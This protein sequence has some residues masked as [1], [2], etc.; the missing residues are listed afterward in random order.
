MSLDKVNVLY[1]NCQGNDGDAY[2]QKAFFDILKENCVDIFCLDEASAD[3]IEFEKNIKAS[4]PS[5][6]FINQG[7]V[8]G[9]FGRLRVFSQLSRRSFKTKKK[10]SR[11]IDICFKKRTNL[12]F[13][14]FRSLYKTDVYEKLKKD[15][16]TILDIYD[17][18]L[19]KRFLIG[20]FNASPFSTTMLDSRFLNTI[21]CGE[22]HFNIKRNDLNT[23]KRINPSWSGFAENE[24]GI[25][26]TLPRNAT[27]L[28]NIGLQLFDQ[29]VF[30]DGLQD[31][32]V[33][34]SFKIISQIN[35]VNIFDDDFK[36]CL[37]DHLPIFFSFYNL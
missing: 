27:S 36:S 19:E 24:N 17:S 2:F 20:D 15:E 33:P 22:E 4:L 25:Y 23:R 35:G 12:C 32:Y 9:R 11:Y 6:T 5:F 10:N 34:K 3:K 29:V 7:R 18:V 13:V 31:R 21:R 28:N 14:H 30:D 1:W 26:G 16:E 37:S 8:N